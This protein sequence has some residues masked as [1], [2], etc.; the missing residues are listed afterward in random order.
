MEGVKLTL[1]Q[2]Q[3]VISYKVQTL[4]ILRRGKALNVGLS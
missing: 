3:M 1:A 4:D 2:V